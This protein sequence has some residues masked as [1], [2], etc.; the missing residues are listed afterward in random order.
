MRR[1][2]LGLQYLTASTSG[3]ASNDSPGLSTA[4]ALGSLSVHQFSEL[5]DSR[6]GCKL[7][8][9]R[10]AIMIDMRDEFNSSIEKLKKEFINNN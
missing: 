3:L 1:Y 6:L 8:D 7:Q 4:N 10:T 9:F 5:L 2:H